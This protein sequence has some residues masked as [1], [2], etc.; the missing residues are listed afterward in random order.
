MDTKVAQRRRHLRPKL[1]LPILVRNQKG[2]EETARTENVAHG[3]VEVY[4]RMTLIVGDTVTVACPYTDGA[5]NNIEQKAEVAH[6]S[7]QPFNGRFRYGLRY[8]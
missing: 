8:L 2:K 4:L 7:M 5:S 1:S 6:R 3:G